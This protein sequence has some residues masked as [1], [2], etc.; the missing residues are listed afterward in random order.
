[1]TDMLAVYFVGGTDQCFQ[2]H[3]VNTVD[4]SYL[5]GLRQGPKEAYQEITLH[6]ARSRIKPHE[7]EFLP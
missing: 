2:Y 1:M 5:S 3:S 4:G 6:S 7:R